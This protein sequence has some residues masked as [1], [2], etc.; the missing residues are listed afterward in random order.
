M[1]D[2]SQLWEQALPYDDFVAASDLKHRGL[3][4]G[5]HRLARIPA[6][7]VAASAARGTSRVSG[8]GELRVNESDRLAALAANLSRLGIAVEESP[9]GLAITGGRIRGGDLEASGDH[10]IAMALTLIATRASEPVTISGAE[11]IPTS[12]P[13]FLDTLAALTDRPRRP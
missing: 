6:W 1:L 4:H 8:A 3:W 12:Y 13:G 5:L 2:F 10:R 11:G 9:D 7:A